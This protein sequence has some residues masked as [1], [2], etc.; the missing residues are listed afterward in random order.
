ME[1]FVPFSSELWVIFDGKR[2][3]ILYSVR[4]YNESNQYLTGDERMNKNGFAKTPPMGWNSYDY[5]DTSVTEADVRANAEYMADKLKKY[6]WEYVVVDIEWYANGA[7]KKRD[8]YQYIPFDDL[9][10]DEFSRLQPSPE[11]F[12]SSAGGKG[13]GPLASYVHSL[14]LKFGIHI[15]RGIPRC[16]AHRHLNVLGAGT[17]ADEVA[18][19][20]SVCGWNPDMYGVRLNEAGQAYYDSI[21]SMYAGWGVD[22][23]KCDDI[24]DSWMYPT[25][26]FSGW[27]ETRMIRRALDKCGRNI[28]LS[29]SPGPAH[30]DMAYHYTQNA[31]MWRITDDFWDSWELLKNMFWRCE[32]W[33][34][35]VRE[36]C[37]PDCDML[38]VG[39]L[40]KGHGHEWYSNFTDDE[41]KTM[42]TL[43]CIFRS[44]LMI[45][46]DLPQLDEKTLKLLTNSDVLEMLKDGRGIQLRRDDR[47]AVWMSEGEDSLRLALF[48]LSD[49][50]GRISAGTDELDANVDFST[51][52]ELWGEQM[53]DITREKIC[54]DVPPHGVRVYRFDK[55]EN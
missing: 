18:D 31:N 25:G 46:T 30:V 6:G 29:L 17:T 54:A 34:D 15:M 8:R 24:C 21:I 50:T 14:G 32:Q 11:R 36:G 41:L 39:K 44:P 55:G 42:L 52:K 40:G 5:Y 43:W 3:W 26:K 37:W 7:G 53:P 9:E 38:P 28:V 2:C 49:E 47:E 33:Q 23:I 35:H 22:F 19:P 16:A 45:G 13:F 51:A 10:I 20:A 4:I 1:S 27:E 12:P 48:N